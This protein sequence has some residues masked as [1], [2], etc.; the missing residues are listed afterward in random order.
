MVSREQ[1][2]LRYG[3]PLFS[4]KNPAL[5]PNESWILDYETMIPVSQKYLPLNF[6]VI[7]NNS[8]GDI[9]VWFDDNKDNKKLIPKNTIL[10]FENIWFRKLRIVNVSDTTISQNRIEFTAQRLPLSDELAK[11]TEIPIVQKIKLLLGW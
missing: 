5:A 6:L 3:S 9:E 10:S 8:E 7:T 11:T 1:R 2:I 4:Y